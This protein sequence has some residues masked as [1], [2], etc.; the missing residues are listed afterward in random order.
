MNHVSK[1]VGRDD[2]IIQ[3][4]EINLFAV[5]PFAVCGFFFII[6]GIVLFMDSEI[7]AGEFNIAI[8]AIILLLGYLDIRST[9]LGYS[10]KKVIGK[11]GLFGEKAMESPLNKVDS[12]SISKGPFGMMLNYSKITITTTSG[13]Y[14]IK[15]IKNGEQFKQDLMDAIDDYEKQKLNEQAEQLLRMRANEK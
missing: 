12:V 4:A 15:Y 13:K 5:T 11:C 10:T 1:K 8:G 3:A 6:P 14:S 9:H 7:I 2:H